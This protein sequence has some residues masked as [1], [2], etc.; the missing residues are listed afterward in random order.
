MSVHKREVEEAALALETFKAVN[1]KIGREMRDTLTASFRATVLEAIRLKWGSPDEKFLDGEDQ[2]N[3]FVR[4]KLPAIFRRSKQR[5]SG[6]LS[7]T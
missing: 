2:F 4:R 6:Q 7:R 3:E 5:Y 1:R